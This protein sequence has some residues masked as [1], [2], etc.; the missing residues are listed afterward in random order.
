ME[1]LKHDFPEIVFKILLNLVNI[2]AS[3]LISTADQLTGVME[4]LYLKYHVRDLS[5]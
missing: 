3:H 1:V 5:K 4:A 2:E